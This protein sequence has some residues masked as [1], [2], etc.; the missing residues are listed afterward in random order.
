MYLGEFFFVFVLA[1]VLSLILVSGLGWRHPRSD[2]VLASLAFSFVLIGLFA[3]LASAWIGPQGPTLWGVSWVPM[4]VV[5]LLV[6]LVILSLAVP[7]SEPPVGE[8][9]TA[10]EEQRAVRSQ[11]R[12]YTY[13]VAF[14][15][16]VV[17]TITAAI[18][19][20]TIL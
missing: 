20:D 16:L 13:G 1:S 17:A 12:L 4:A 11:R 8:R 5:S 3:W 15:V 10:R 7:P 18:F 6:A 14:W 9:R 19:G 2:D